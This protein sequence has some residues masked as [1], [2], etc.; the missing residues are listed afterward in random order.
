MEGSWYRGRWIEEIVGDALN[1][2]EE[3]FRERY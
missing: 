1:M 3:Y 2:R